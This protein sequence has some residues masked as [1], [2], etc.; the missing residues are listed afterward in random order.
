MEKAAPLSRGRPKT[1]DRDRVLCVAMEQ[2]W[3][4][5]PHEVSIN[6]ICKLADASKPGVY[7]EFGSDDRLKATALMA[8]KA[9]AI[10]PFLALLE[11]GDGLTETVNALIAFMMQDRQAQNIPEGCLFVSMRAQRNRL[12]PETQN[13]LD[14]LRTYFLGSFALWIDATKAA[15]EFRRDVPTGMAAHFIDSLHAG[16]TRMQKENAPAEDVETMLRFGFSAISG[17]HRIVR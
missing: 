16:A 4:H 2:Y 3:R 5:G 1:L 6:D 8:Y 12:G 9:L 14:E 13:S 11:S 17:D 7:R 15:G 10:D